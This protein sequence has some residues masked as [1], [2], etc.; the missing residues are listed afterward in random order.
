VATSAAQ[1]ALDALATAA[2]GDQSGSGVVRVPAVSGDATEVVF[3]DRSGWEP[4]GL[5]SGASVFH[6]GMVG[7]PRGN[8]EVAQLSK[9]MYAARE[10]ALSG[11]R[12]DAARLGA[13]G[14]VNT[15]LDVHF[16]ADHRHLPRFVATG[17]A[18]RPTRA[19]RSRSQD[20]PA[21]F[22]TTMSAAE[23]GLLGVSGYRPVGLVM[24]SCVYHVGRRSLAEWA[25]Y[26]RRNTELASYSAAL[27]DAREIA[28]TRLQ[29]EARQLAADGV[30]G[31]TTAERSH[32]WGSRVIEFF[33]L[34]TAVEGAPTT[35]VAG[36]GMVVSL[37]DP[38]VGVEPRSIVQSRQN[39]NTEA[40]EQTASP[41]SPRHGDAG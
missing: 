3:L 41:P 22:I 2:G 8:T 14:V 4:C 7:W 6:V 13:D 5:V 23:M 9:A 31:V 12:V 29:D 36:P 21:P 35:I 10:D 1:A 16:M 33:A 11:L 39:K 32:V 15:T 17:T 40:D 37:N 30:V 28:M 19:S 18:I 26:L 20:Q 34:G 38:N 24:G 27:Y 25:R